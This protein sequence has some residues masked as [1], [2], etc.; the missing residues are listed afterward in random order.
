MIRNLWNLIKEGGKVVALLATLKGQIDALSDDLAR[1]E[2]EL[3]RLDATVE[4]LARLV[5]SSR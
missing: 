3:I 5:E 4:E 1:V 2:H